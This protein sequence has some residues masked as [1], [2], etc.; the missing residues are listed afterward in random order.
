MVGLAARRFTGKHCDGKHE[1]MEN[2]KTLG[3]VP[4][5]F[6]DG[7]MPLFKIDIT[8]ENHHLFL[9]GK[10]TTTDHFQ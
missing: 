1:E 9:M 3:T 8:M 10:L 2:K 5:S 6:A 4:A 7:G